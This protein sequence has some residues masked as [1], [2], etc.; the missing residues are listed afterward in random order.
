M[1]PPASSWGR[2]GVLWLTGLALLAGCGSGSSVKITGAPS[3]A[4]Y[5]SCL[6]E[7]G[8]TYPTESPTPGAARPTRDPATVSAF[9]KARKTCAALRPPGALRPSGLHE[10]TREHFAQCMA[11]HGVPLPE[12]SEPA[13]PPPGDLQ[14]SDSPTAPRGGILTGLDRNDPNTKAALTAC[15]SL[16][17]VP[18]TT[19]VPSGTDT[20]APS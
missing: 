6:E 9:K 3:L 7:H 2:S 14:P 11:R 8:V 18:Q 19:V 1:R 4:A 17:V 10:A 5:R 13:T 15:R 20:P 12:P 16:L